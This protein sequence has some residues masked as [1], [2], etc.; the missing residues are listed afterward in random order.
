MEKEEG[1]IRVLK[2]KADVV[3]WPSLC[4]QSTI[5]EHYLK[6]MAHLWH[7]LPHPAPPP[8]SRDPAWPGNRP[9]PQIQ[10]LI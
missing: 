4:H 10:A 3:C 5:P 6:S 2:D 7:L 1:V 9:P 8:T